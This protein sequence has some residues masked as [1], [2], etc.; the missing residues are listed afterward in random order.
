[1]S[2]CTTS[3]PA[4]RS[5]QVVSVLCYKTRH[6]RSRTEFSSPV[7]AISYLLID[8]LH[9]LR[10][11]KDRIYDPQHSIFISKANR[12]QCNMCF[13]TC[14]C[15]YCCCVCLLLWMLGISNVHIACYI[16]M[17]EREPRTALFLILIARG[18]A[19]T[20]S[21]LLI[22]MLL[23]RQVHPRVLH[24]AGG[25]LQCLKFDCFTGVNDFENKLQ[26]YTF[27]D[28][29]VSDRFAYNWK[30]WKLTL[31]PGFV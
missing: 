19:N 30:W 1:M 9:W 11:H 20:L 13:W 31:M 24:Q 14:G 21:P 2:L 6:P 23:S 28:S 8:V 26:Y 18:R 12:G 7:F 10:I 25:F 22:C 5:S 16:C 4:S 17:A 27:Y 29:I 15:C 3:Q